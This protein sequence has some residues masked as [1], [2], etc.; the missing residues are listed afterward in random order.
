MLLSF[1]FFL[2]EKTTP[3]NETPQNRI[4]C[5]TTRRKYFKE[6]TLI[7]VFTNVNIKNKNVNL[8]IS[9]Y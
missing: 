6:E 7:Y 9:L 1:I 3:R 8:L 2:V 4:Q 5:V